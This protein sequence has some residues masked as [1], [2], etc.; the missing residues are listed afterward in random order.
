MGS[1]ELLPML[2]A[3]GLFLMVFI[4]LR[5]F[6]CWY[7]KVNQILELQQQIVSLLAQQANREIKG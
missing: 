7:W 5:E 3:I 6:W 4:L 2:L 1:T